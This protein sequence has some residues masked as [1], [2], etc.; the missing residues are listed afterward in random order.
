MN[1]KVNILQLAQWLTGAT[2]KNKGFLLKPKDL[3]IIYLLFLW[4]Y[5]SKHHTD[6][7]VT[8]SVP[9][10]NDDSEISIPEQDLVNIV[11]TF[12]Q[13]AYY[14]YFTRLNSI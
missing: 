3:G 11:Q 7:K 13:K 6:K 2:C 4:E 10:I 8:D 14:P 9:E 5:L 1:K 12:Y